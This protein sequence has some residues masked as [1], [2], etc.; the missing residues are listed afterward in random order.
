[1]S[2]DNNHDPKNSSNLTS[3][4]FRYQQHQQIPTNSLASR[5]SN[6]QTNS[7]SSF[8]SNPNLNHQ[9]NLPIQSNSN[10]PSIAKRSSNPPQIFYPP[11]TDFDAIKGRFGLNLSSANRSNLNS[12]LSS[13]RRDQPAISHQKWSSISDL[14]SSNSF[15][16]PYSAS[17]LMSNG[18][19][20]LERSSSAHRRRPL[21]VIDPSV[22]INSFYHHHSSKSI[23]QKPLERLPENSFERSNFHSRRTHSSN[24]T[25]PEADQLIPV[26]QVE[27]VIGLQGRLRLSKDLPSSP[28]SSSRVIGGLKLLESQRHLLQ[29][30]EYLCHVGEAKDWLEAVLAMDSVQHSLTPASSV[31]PS[32]L[33]NSPTSSTID[34]LHHLSVTEF[35]QT[36][37]DGVILATLARRFTGF[38]GVPR[39]FIHPKLQYRHSDN[40]NY[41]F[42]FVRGIGLP[43]LFIFELVDLYNAKNLPKVIYCIHVL[44]HLLAKKGMA[45]QI[46]NLVGKLEFSNDQ[47]E[48]TNAGLIGKSMPN[49]GDINKELAKECK[50]EFEPEIESEPD[51]ILREL[52]ALIPEIIGLQSQL[53]GYLAR[54]DYYSLLAD[55]TDNFPVFIAFQAAVRGYLQRA[56]RARLSA[57][58]STNLRFITQF[59]AVLRGIRC[60]RKCRAALKLRREL[61]IWAVALQATIRSRLSHRRF[62]KLNMVLGK[63]DFLWSALQAHARGALVRAHTQKVQASVNKCERAFIGVQ[64]LVRARL[65]SQEIQERKKRLE[66]LDVSNSVIGLQAHIRGLLERR[67]FFEPIHQLDIHEQA[68]VKFQGLIR[69]KLVQER[70]RKTVFDLMASEQH[71]ARF[72]SASRGALSRRALFKFIQELQE[73]V[74]SIIDFQALCRAT[75]VRRACAQKAKALNKVEVT[76]G[77]GGLQAFVRAGLIRKKIVNQKKEL[78]F[79]QPDVVGIQAQC[80]GVLARLDWGVWFEHIRS[81]V[82]VAIFLQSLT[83]GFLVRREFFERLMH[84]HD[85]V[86]KVIKVQSIYRARQQASQYKALTRGTNVPMS[87]I[88][89]F[90]HLLSDS[91][92]DYEEEIAISKLRTD[93]VRLIRDNQQLDIHVNE[94]DTKIALLVKNKITLDDVQRASGGGRRRKDILYRNSILA[95]AN[96]PFASVNVLDKSAKRKLELYQ[97]FFYLLQTKPEYLARLFFL[98]KAQEEKVKKILEGV[99]L[100][101]FGYA[102]MRRE[103]FLLLKLFQVRAYVISFF[104]PSRKFIFIKDLKVRFIY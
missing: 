11:K 68:M 93:V 40:I 97:Q 30:Y 9:T 104:G 39:I 48:Q 29:A 82:P 59:Q 20:P 86:H 45:E 50:E 15:S 10:S 102:Q 41:F 43:E 92:L 66:S 74:P 56:S 83:R 16:T 6:R 98:I 37:R 51:R 44:S 8:Q 14:S 103:E 35:E 22:K 78:D 34:G 46:G 80:R 79:I 70:L 31:L 63:L 60:R 32:P 13:Y 85:Q 76:R 54:F 27:D 53:R 95:A 33:L 75:L 90:L 99:V 55:L 91:D 72:Q 52:Q 58:L 87:A 17:S 89:S 47:L 100:T 12:S 1:M 5:L 81:S 19:T 84:Y 77:V 64:A 49:F 94:L 73:C 25:H 36:L 61:D 26:G 4:S 71:V 57:K 2:K 18:S 24:P 67:R 23:D 65:M 62:S 42:Q 101:L 96:D 88:K 21:S 38:E 3:N 7:P 69:T 28:V